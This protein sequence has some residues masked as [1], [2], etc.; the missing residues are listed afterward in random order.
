MEQLDE[1]LQKLGGAP[2]WQK[3]AGVLVLVALIGAGYWYFFLDEIW[4]QREQLISQQNKLN[5]EKKE[6]ENRKREYLAYR[7][8]V[9][10]LLDE[11][12]DV[13]RLLPKKDDIEQFVEAVQQQIELAGLVRSALVRDPPAAQELFIRLPVKMTVYGSYHQLMRFFKSMGEIP[14]IVNIEDLKL[15][16]AGTGGGAA[17]QSDKDLVPD[18]LK[19]EFIAVAFQYLD[20]Q[21][22]RKA[23]GGDGAMKAVGQSS[24]G[25][26]Q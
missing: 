19:A 25:G 20:R 17:S 3:L 16:P 12:K 9:A 11:Q 7:K 21:P 10:Q 14:R 4:S 8:E 26:G 1:L 15:N 23:A 18:S 6:Y 22:P 2:P 13:L 24:G 5:N